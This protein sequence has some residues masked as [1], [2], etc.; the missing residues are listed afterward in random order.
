MGTVNM[1]RSE[2]GV[3]SPGKGF[4]DVCDPSCGFWK[5]N[6]CALQQQQ[7]NHGA[8]SLSPYPYLSEPGTYLPAYINW[9]ASKPQGPGTETANTLTFK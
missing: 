9:L 7:S 8:L 3:G 6:L 4:I 5:L 1:Q 2:E